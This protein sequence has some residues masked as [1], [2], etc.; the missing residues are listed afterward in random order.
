MTVCVKCGCTDERACPGG[1]AWSQISVMPLTHLGREFAAGELGV[2]DNCDDFSASA[3]PLRGMDF[4]DFVPDELGDGEMEAPA[5][6]T[7]FDERGIILP[8]DEDFHL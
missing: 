6:G 7:A 2:C 5:I 8:G 3:K 1:C 4:A